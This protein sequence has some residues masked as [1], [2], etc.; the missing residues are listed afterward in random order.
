MTRGWGDAYTFRAQDW[1][2]KL[3]CACPGFETGVVWERIYPSVSSPGAR[4]YF[5]VA[6]VQRSVFEQVR[7]GDEGQTWRVISVTTFLQATDAVASMK[8]R[9]SDFMS[10]GRR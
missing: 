5:F 6:E 4:S 3:K 9:L 8:A 7:F 1:N 10:W 2:L